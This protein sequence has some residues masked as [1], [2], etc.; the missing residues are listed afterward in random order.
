MKGISCP[1]CSNPLMESALSLPVACNRCGTAYYYDEYGSYVPQIAPCTVNEGGATSR[2]MDWAS[3]VKGGR[4]FSKNIELAKMTRRYYPVFVFNRNRNGEQANTIASAIAAAEPG[5]RSIDF[6]GVDIH[7]M[8]GGPIDQGECVKPNLSPAAYVRLLS[9]DPASRTMIY[10]PFWCTQYVY[11][12]KLNTVT[13]DGCTGRVSGDLSVD[14]EK[15]SSM[16][17]AASAFVALGAAG[18]LTLVS[19][20]LTVAAFAA[21]VGATVYYVR[22]RRED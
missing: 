12:G 9:V 22:K 4:E 20:V 1:S 15:R 3:G 21:I 6:S 2:I 5:I 7:T 8:T 16:P 11:H 14:I 17:I 18:A 10:Y 13:V 19:W